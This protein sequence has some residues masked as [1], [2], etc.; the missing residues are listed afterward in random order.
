MPAIAGALVSPAIQNSI[1]KGALETR[2]LVRLQRGGGRAAVASEGDES[3]GD[4]SKGDESKG[5]ES[6]GDESK[7]TCVGSF[8]PT[9]RADADALLAPARLA[10][11]TTARLPEPASLCSGPAYNASKSKF[12]NL[13]KQ[14]FA[15]ANSPSGGL[16][17]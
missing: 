6:K 2:P 16:S 13:S 8:T 9:P 12:R 7:G 5:D 17:G 11:P 15:A 10:A 3:K 1:L 14:S 4:E